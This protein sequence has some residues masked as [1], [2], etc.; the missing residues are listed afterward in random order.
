MKLTKQAVVLDGE[1]CESFLTAA[2]TVCAPPVEKVRLR[3][4]RKDVVKK[5]CHT[6]F[7]EFYY[8]LEEKQL[9]TEG[10]VVSAD[11]ILRDKLNT[12]SVDERSLLETLS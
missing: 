12:Y 7:R 3:S 8:A 10:K 6:K 9:K 2:K 5:V 11:Q 4:I 1:L